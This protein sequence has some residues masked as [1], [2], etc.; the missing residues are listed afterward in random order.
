MTKKTFDISSKLKIK[1]GSVRW[2]EHST[3]IEHLLRMC[4]TLCSTPIT[5]RIVIRIIRTKIVVVI[6]PGK[7]IHL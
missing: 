4:K 7:K 1:L 5:A 6:K 2:W 3:A